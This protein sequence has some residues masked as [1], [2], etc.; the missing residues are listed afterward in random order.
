MAILSAA[1]LDQQA[2]LSYVRGT[3]HVALLYSTTDFDSTILYSDVTDAELASG[4]GGYTRVSFT[5]SS[6]DLEAYANGQPLARKTANFVH[7]GS[8]NSLTFTHIALLREVSSVYTV[9]AVQALGDIAI[10]ENGNT[11]S[12]NVDILHGKI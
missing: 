5:Y 11:A 12:I 6:E 1:E 4:T 7:D 2:E 9:V 10:L 8:S 3:Y